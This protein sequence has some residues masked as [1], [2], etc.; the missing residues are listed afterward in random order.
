MGLTQSGSCFQ[1]VKSPWVKAAPRETWPDGSQ[2]VRRRLGKRVC[3]SCCVARTAQRR[4]PAR[5]RDRPAASDQ[6]GDPA[7]V[8]PIAQ[9]ASDRLSDAGGL[10]F[11]SQT[12]LVMGKSIPSLWRD[13]H[14]AVKGLRPPEHHAGH[15]IR[16]KRLLQVVKKKATSLGSGSVHEL[17]ATCSDAAIA[18]RSCAT[19]DV[20]PIHMKYTRVHAR[21][22]THVHTYARMRW[23]ITGVRLLR[24]L[25]FFH[26]NVTC[27]EQSLVVSCCRTYFCTSRKCFGIPHMLN[28]PIHHPLAGV[29]EPRGEEARR[30][31]AHLPHGGRGLPD[32]QMRLP[33]MRPFEPDAPL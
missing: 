27:S 16:N 14:P 29:G 3:Q 19:Y 8:A 12:G 10:G 2:S 31:G 20:L 11:E 7:I 1:K 26:N 30:S 4:P 24:G 22:R 25:S 17:Q 21:M 28:P 6:E 32:A 13:K 5:Q 15:S 18:T 33:L 9:L 23:W